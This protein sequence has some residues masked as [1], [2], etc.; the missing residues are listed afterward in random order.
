MSRDVDWVDGWEIHARPDGGYGVYDAHGMVLG[1]FGTKNQAI[2]AALQL[3]KHSMT[4]P[5]ARD[6]SADHRLGNR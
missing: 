6:Q 4:A 1:P 2:A 5:T 3:P